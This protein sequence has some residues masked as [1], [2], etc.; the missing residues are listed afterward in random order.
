MVLTHTQ[1]IPFLFFTDST[2]PTVPEE[3]ICYIHGL[4]P[5]KNARNSEKKYFD[6]TLQ[7]KGV[8]AVLFVSHNRKN[9]R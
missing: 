6:C 1:N 9:L 7:C 5:V 4:L 2:T 3:I 8:I